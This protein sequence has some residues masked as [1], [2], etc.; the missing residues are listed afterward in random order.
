MRYN[1]RTQPNL[2]Q[3]E[4]YLTPYRLSSFIIVLATDHS[5]DDFGLFRY[6]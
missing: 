3:V 5:I 2:P 1:V 6:K 4:L